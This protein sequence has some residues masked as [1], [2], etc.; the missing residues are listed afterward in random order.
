MKNK[1]QLYEIEYK[2][3]GQKYIGITWGKNHSYLKRFKKHLNKR[4]SVYIKRLIENGAKKEDFFVRLIC[5]DCLEVIRKK[6]IEL[7]CLYPEGLNG[8][9]GCVILL[10]EDVIK[11]ATKSRMVNWDKT[12]KKIRDTLKGVSYD[13]RFGIEK[14]KEIKR[15]ISQANIGKKVTEETR[16]KLRQANIGKKVTEETREKLRQAKIGKKCTEHHKRKTSNSM[17]KYINSLTE[18]NKKIRLDRSLRTCDNIERGKNISKGK[19]GKKTNQQEIMM[20]KY[21]SMSD[22]E[23]R[24]WCIGRKQFVI[25]RAK[26]LRDK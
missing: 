13:E 1:A 6:E 2:P 4:G 8:N 11:K 12:K 15:K 26:N 24:K 21:K 7:S 9:K 17:K 18:E 20:N 10:T 14:S 5:E 16:E 22:E 19:K 3:T 25:T 23:F